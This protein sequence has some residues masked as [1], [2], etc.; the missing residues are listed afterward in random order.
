MDLIYSISK[1]YQLTYG[2]SKIIV[3][4]I[5]KFITEAILKGHRVELR[6]FGTFEMRTHKAYKGRNPK[7]GEAIEIPAKK[8]PFFKA[9]KIIKNK[10]TS[11]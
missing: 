2:V 4:N 7:T 6:G 5:F 11:S 8:Q 10:L 9:G 3:D 1:K